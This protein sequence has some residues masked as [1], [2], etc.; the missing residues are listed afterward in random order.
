MNSVRQHPRRFGLT[1]RQC[2]GADP[3]LSDVARVAHA[4]DRHPYMTDQE[5]YDCDILAGAMHPE[6]TQFTYIEQ[7]S[8][9]EPGGID[10]TIKIHHVT[11]DGENRSEIIETY[12][13]FFGC[14]VR[15]LQWH[16][17][18]VVLVYREKHYTYAATYGKDWPPVFRRIGDR[19]KKNSTKLVYA[20]AD[21]IFEQ[22]SLPELRRIGKLSE[23]QAKRARLFPEA[24]MEYL[25]W[26]ENAG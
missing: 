11:D 2:S 14:N 10:V 3:N 15:H 17:N 26:P 5:G 22:L 8:K 13:P 9:T 7:R 23:T 19:W 16:G 12:N 4:L 25:D 6:T 24:L 1:L 21:G 18:S 20:N